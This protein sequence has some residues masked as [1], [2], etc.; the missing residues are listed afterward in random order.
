MTRLPARAYVEVWIVLVVF[1][2]SIAWR[3]LSVPWDFGGLWFQA[4]S[5]IVWMAALAYAPKA[6]RLLR[7]GHWFIAV[8]IACSAAFA[9]I[10]YAAQDV[11]PFAFAG[12]FVLGAQQLREKGKGTQSLLMCLLLLPISVWMIASIV[13][14]RHVYEFRHLRAES[15]SSIEFRLAGMPQK[16]FR[17]TSRESI[18]SI[19][20]ALAYTH[21]YSPNHES[22]KEP[23]SVSIRLRT[24]RAYDFELGHGNRAYPQAG[25]IDIGAGTYQNLSLCRVLCSELRLPL[26]MAEAER[27][28]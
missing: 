12:F 19:A 10:Y 11:L 14:M 17:L 7:R 18:A 5:S 9:S 28:Q 3:F 15:V 20:H 8:P 2:A 16:S 26:W 21:P 25:W 6:S 23:W 24:G 13:D 1:A 22:I 4:W 27:T